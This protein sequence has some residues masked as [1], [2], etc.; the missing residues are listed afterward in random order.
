LGPGK[1]RSGGNTASYRD[2]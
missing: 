1:T 2:V